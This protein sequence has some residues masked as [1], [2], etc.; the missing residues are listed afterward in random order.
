MV[1]GDHDGHIVTTDHLDEVV[2][3]TSEDDMVRLEVLEP[4]NGCSILLTPDQARD[5]AIYLLRETRLVEKG[6]G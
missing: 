4:G 2:K 5:V 6:S 3:I 1:V